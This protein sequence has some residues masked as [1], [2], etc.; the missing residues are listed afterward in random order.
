[1]RPVF[2]L[3]AFLLAPLLAGAQVHFTAALDGAQAGVVTTA[4]GTGSFS[5]NEDRTE[6][7]YEITYQGLSG[8]LSAGGHFHTGKPGIGGPVV[9]GIAAG[10]AAASGTLSGVWK[11]TD[12]S[13]PLTA[14][15]VESLLTGRVYVNLH[16]TAH[17]SGEIRGQVVLATALHFESLLDGAQAGV[18]TT[19]GGTGVFVLNPERTEVRYW[20]TYRGLSGPLS[21]GGHVHAGAP[22]VSGPI[23]RTLGA[24]GDPGSASLKGTWKADDASQPLTPAL[25]DS[26]IAGRLYANFHTTANPGNEIRGQLV[27]A[28]GYGFVA[29][30]EGSAQNPPVQTNASGTGS[31]ALNAAGT[32][33]RYAITY[34]NL[35]GPLSAGGHFHTGKPGVNGPVVK[36]IATSNDSASKTVSGVWRSSDISQPLTPALV[37]SLFT[38][39]AYVNYHTTAHGAGEIRGQLE[40]T[41]GIGFTAHLDGA[42]QSPPVATAGVGT[43]VF[44]LNA[45]RKDLAYQ[46]TYFGLSG[47]LSAGGHFHAGAPGVSGSIV[48]NISASSAPAAA[49]VADDWSSTDGAQPLTPALVDSLIAG[50]VYVNFHTTAHGAG[51]IRGQL[52]FGAEP[53]VTAVAAEEP[54]VPDGFRLEQNYPNPFNPSTTIR[55]TLHSA[56]RVR[57]RVY[58]VLGREVATLVDDLRASGTHAVNF[59]ARSLASGVYVYAL[60]TAGGLRQTHTMLLLR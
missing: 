10:G 57:L 50:H 3:C 7:R 32:E 58:D 31:I 15:L 29:D 35:S 14:V 22:G 56:A 16:T 23:V 33:L 11:S 18:S 41:T 38:G 44:V 43:G 27:L 12:A 46:I 39:R 51:E 28:G 25:V 48:R 52:R 53:T 40:L 19:A 6:L 47:P 49:T 36:G 42:Q 54:G 17:G 5:L 45:E 2:S 8:T 55:F 26:L 1:M 13:Q 30:L 21:I 4:S 24:P 34:I 60:S 9:R 59:D 37:E 20:V